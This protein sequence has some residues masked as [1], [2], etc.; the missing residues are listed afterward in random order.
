MAILDSDRDVEAPTIVLTV[1]MPPSSNALW[2]TPRGHRSRIRSPE[3]SAWLREAGWDIRRQMA[4]IP[5]IAG[6]FTA[7]IEVPAKSR[8]DLDN[9]VKPLLDALQHANAINN[10]SGNRGMTVV[11]TQ[12]DDVMLALWDCGGPALKPA[13][14]LLN[15]GGY[16]K[17]TRKGGITTAALLGLTRR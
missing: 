4:G 13:K 1:R 5:P 9:H 12:R 3:Y 14:A 2:I 16:R 10:D 11:P 6:A 15:R 8:R 7:R 17:R